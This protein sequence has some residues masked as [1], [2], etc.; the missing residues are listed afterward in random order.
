MGTL[1][2]ANHNHTVPAVL[3]LSLVLASQSAHAVTLVQ[4]SRA[5]SVIVLAD[6]P[7]PAA[8]T[9]AAE[10]QAYLQKISGAT[11]PIGAES[12]TS[13]PAG[14]SLILVGDS[15][16][17]AELGLTSA[18][19]GLESISIRATDNTLAILGRDARP[20]GVELRGTEWA[21][22]VFLEKYLG[23]RWLWPGELGEVVPRQ[24]TIELPDIDYAYTPPLR[25]RKIRNYR[26]LD[27]IQRG[28]DKL[29]FSREDF[30]KKHADSGPWFARHR[31]GGSMRLSYG[32]A[33]G[34]WWDEYGTEHPEWFALQPD[35]TRD[36][37]G[38]GNRARL[39]VSNEGLIA[40]AAR[41]ACEQLEADE[42]RDSVSISPNDG[43]RTTFCMCDGCKAWDVP[44]AEKVQIRRPDGT[45]LEYPSLS[46]RYV[47]FYARVADIVAKRCP[48]RFLGAY[49]YSVYRTPPVRAKLPP[50]LII[51]FVGF[52]YLNDDS[53][54]KAREWW[55]G[56]AKAAHKL[57][58][59]P[60]LLHRGKG[61]PVLFPHKLAKD[62]R[63]CASTGMIVTDF[64][65]CVHH[66]A[67]NGL[68]YYVLARLL[69]DPRANVD[70]I[71]ADYCRAG[72]GRAAPPVKRY[73]AKL[74]RLTSKL[75]ATR[76][77][78]GRKVNH[79]VLAELYSD[80]VLEELGDLLD[81]AE[82]LAEGDDPRVAERIQFL[83][84]GLDFTRVNRDA[85]LAQH[86]AKVGKLA[87][88][89][90]LQAALDAREAFYQKLGLSWEINSPY[91][92]FYGY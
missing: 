39:C 63:Y 13:L 83:R 66:W 46:D 49:A 84:V 91:L 27:R 75:A 44:E 7:T 9:A 76:T 20:D 16:R 26:N 5:R 43:G 89:A 18:D 15:K 6:E 25:Q 19:L 78:Q 62:L 10:L 72:F 8:T 55:A 60:N 33:Y 51:G 82:Q 21:A 90:A 80:R 92:K 23:V 40:E 38:V 59:R 61:F 58:L 47:T 65:S 68:N 36:Q 31:I 34:S 2:T 28:L 41:R 69:W 50:N 4:D 57:F 48:G 14:A 1:H 85:I 12:R 77:Y 88:K 73:F 81:R 22:Y 70:K 42:Q 67:T 11:V 45:Y 29:G 87:E 64:D 54:D 24:S 86:A 17:A 30:L 53:R 56:W 3:G 35:G 52:D 74:E 32:H 37:S 71:I 79:Y